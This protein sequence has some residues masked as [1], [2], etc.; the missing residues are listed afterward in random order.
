MMRVVKPCP[1]CG[2][3]AVEGPLWREHYGCSDPECGAYGANLSLAQW[4]RRAKDA[5]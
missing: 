1:F 5:A 2:A 4:N 3:R